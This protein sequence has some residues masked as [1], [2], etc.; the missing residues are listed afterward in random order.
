[1]YTAILYIRVSTDEQ[2]QKGYSQRSQEEK[3]NKYC[4]DNQIE[5]VQTIF[6]DHTAKS[7]DRPAWNAMMKQLHSSK[8]SRPHMILFTRWDRFSRNTANAYYMITQLGKMGIEL[9]TTDQPL[10]MAIP[11]NK[12]LLAMYIVT[13]EVEND[14]RSLN[15]KQGILKAKKEGR[16]MGRAPI[17]Y[18]NISLP[19]GRKTIVPHEPEA[20]LVRKAFES[21]GETSTRFH[22]KTTVKKGLK[23]SLNAF[24]NMLRNSVYCGKITVPSTERTTRYEVP[25]EHT[26]LISEELFNLVQSRIRHRNNKYVKQNTNGQLLFR[27]FL[28]CPLCSK[29]LS[30]SGSK[31]STKKYF[32]YHCYYPCG[33]RIRADQVNDH[34]LLAIGRL[35]PEMSYIP[36]FESLVKKIHDNECQQ[37]SMDKVSVIRSLHKLMERAAN[38]RELLVKGTINE[39]DYLSIKSD[40]ENS[41]D[42]LGEQL[43][44]AYKFEVQQKQSLTKLT[45]FFSSPELIFLRTHH[46]IQL[47]AAA[48]FL[49]E[50]LVYSEADILCY[51][52][53]EVQMICGFSPTNTMDNYEKA[54]DAVNLTREKDLLTR[55]MR[56]EK[57]KGRE[58]DIPD[59]LKILSFLSDL[60]KICISVKML[61]GE[62]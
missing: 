16:Y 1:M 45:A 15:I 36:I 47:K 34:L 44:D 46:S 17:G 50:K 8:A 48:L 29:K 39:E 11:E 22:Y 43:N 20:T 9:Q 57:D 54:E 7:F 40:C 30:G 6:E 42:I 12:V 26:P 32:Y 2:A 38:A 49:K 10:D 33:Y 31:G 13:A 19:D 23:C 62:N 59:T 3:L 55:I 4:K 37:K 21:F 58:I 24:F 53:P 56:V 61:Q 41:I 27:G 52:K 60:A 14:R 35:R 51:I 28:H 25:G 18:I 5:I